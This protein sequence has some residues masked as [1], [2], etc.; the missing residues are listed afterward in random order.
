M[1][2]FKVEVVKVEKLE[3]HPNADSLSVVKVKGWQCI[4]KTEEFKGVKLAV[5]VPIDS[6]CPQSS[7]W[8][9]LKDRGYRVRTIK[10]RG[11]L[12]QGLLIPAKKHWKLGEDVAKKLGIQKYEP[13]IPVHLAGDMIRN[14]PGF[15]VYTSIESWK[16]YP[17]VFTGGEDVYV[18]EKIHGTNT[19]YGLIEGKFCV[20][21]H[22]TCRD[23]EGKNIYS[24]IAREYD[25][26]NRLKR[27]MQ[28][29]DGTNI[30]IYGEIFGKS[31]QDLR[32]GKQKPEF[33][34][35]DLVVDGAFADPHVMVMLFKEMG[36]AT[37]PIL[38]HGPFS[39]EVLKLSDGEAFAGG[40]IREGIVVKSPKEDFHPEIGRKVLKKTSDSFYL[41]KEGTEYH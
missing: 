23:P 30:I 39:N 41:R 13:P 24:T 21:T 16:N 22:K 28:Y 4:I 15:Q 7:E 36:L 14:I 26:K 32:Y 40:H 19:R 31:I 5:Y 37:V 10:L 20:G 1:S 11:L 35:F 27:V 8:E 18:T 12:S 38:F 34:G 17:D 3:K 29:I 6:V 25:I 2:S 9:F 33:V